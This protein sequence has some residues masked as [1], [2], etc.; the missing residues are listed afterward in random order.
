[1]SARV[2][3][4]KKSQL[5]PA[6]GCRERSSIIAGKGETPVPPANM[7]TGL[8]TSTGRSKRGGRTT[9]TESL[10][11]SA[12]AA[13]GSVRKPD[14]VPRCAV[15]RV[16]AKALLRMSQSEQLREIVEARAEDQ[17]GLWE[18]L[19]LLAGTGFRPARLWKAI[20]GER[21]SICW[22]VPPE[23]FRMFSISGI[24]PGGPTEGT[25]DIALTVDRLRYDTK[26]PPWRLP[27][28]H[29]H[30]A[31]PPWQPA[32]N[33]SSAGLRDTARV[34]PGRARHPSGPTGGPRS[35]LRIHRASCCAPP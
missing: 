33:G 23:S 32:R 26:A 27:R 16:V 13:G 31:H 5:G 2:R 14:P 24:S 18:M 19:D 11:P 4:P 9:R 6:S 25:R 1:M 20:P 12:A 10:R 30:G 17:W 29:R 34:A 8:R 15:T 7:T 22:I 3:V 21:E 28:Y 35:R